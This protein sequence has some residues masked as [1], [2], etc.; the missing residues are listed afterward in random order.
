MELA[1]IIGFL[2]AVVGTSLMLPQVVKTIRTKKVDDLSF[3]TLV[4]YFV[5]CV[6]WLAYGVLINA[7]PVIAC[8]FSALII[9]ILQ[10]GLKIKYGK[11]RLD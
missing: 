8:N 10:L 7:W 11:G 3:L 2:A 9:S 6:L 4:L 1:E 5:N